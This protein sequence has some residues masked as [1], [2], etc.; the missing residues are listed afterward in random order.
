MIDTI[1][2]PY[3]TPAW[4]F[5]SARTADGRWFRTLM[6]IDVPLV[7]RRGAPIA[8]TVDNGGEFVSRA[9]DAWAYAHDVRLEFIRPGRPVENSFIES[10]N[11]FAADHLVAAGRP[12]GVVFTRCQ[13]EAVAPSKKH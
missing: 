10:F 11:G 12:A 2:P 4:P 7:S 6:V 1:D 5:V 9:M 13:E 3:Y 8:I